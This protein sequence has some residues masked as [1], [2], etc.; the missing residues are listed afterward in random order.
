MTRT[1]YLALCFLVLFA[2][3]ARAA[4]KQLFVYTWDTYADL[5]LFRKFEKETG[6]KVVT[7]IYSSNDTLLSKLKTGASYDIVAPSGNYVPLLVGENLLQPLPDDLKPAAQG[8]S[9]LVKAPAYDAE[10]KYSLPLFYGTTGIAVDTKFVKE[11]VTSWDQFFHR[12]AE[13]GKQLG[14]IDDTSTVMDIVGIALG[15]PYCEDKPETYQALQD[16]L[17]A[18]KPAVKT[19]SA[20]GYQE[21]LA[22]NEVAMQM[23]WSGDVYRA[24]TNNP[25]IKYVYPKEGV[26][27]WIDN[28]AV[29]AAAKNVEAAKQFIAFAMK[30]ENMA[31]YAQYSGNIPT[32]DAA[33]ALLPEKIRTAPEFNIPAGLKAPISINCPPKVAQTYEKIW[34]RLLR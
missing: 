14:M 3:A 34:E 20:T 32:L 33:K 25:D 5:D 19:Y 10:H 15:K 29:P 27:L 21:R 22:A 16:L 18:Q 11:D 24:R 9:D 17:L 31:V 6:I 1:L 26:E 7:D 4:D 8:L 23:A 2:P 13:A 28:L 12:P 30:P